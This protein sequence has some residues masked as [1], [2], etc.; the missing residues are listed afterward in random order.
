[1]FFDPQHRAVLDKLRFGNEG[2][3][4]IRRAQLPAMSEEYI[5]AV[6]REVGRVLQP[7]GYLMYWIDTF[8]LVEGHH[9]RIPRD[10][11]APVDLL[12]WNCL[13]IGMGKRTRRSGDY[14]LILQRPPI[15]AGAT[16][17]DHGIPS[18]W[19]EKAL[20][21]LHPHAK[22]VGLITRLI[23]A[24]TL[25]GDLVVDPAAGSFIV[26]S[27][28]QL[29]RREFIGCDLAYDGAKSWR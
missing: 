16:W 14:L 6:C 23:T 2:E 27:A 10:C 20:R 21:K 8:R 29:T 5:D 25:P 26:L 7:S 22:P 13:R 3:R 11:I 28:A 18:R 19:A 1:V 4:Q 17:R 9:H 12:A 15:K 24:T